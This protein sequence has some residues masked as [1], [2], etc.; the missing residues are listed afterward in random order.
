MGVRNLTRSHPHTTH[1][2]HRAQPMQWHPHQHQN[3]SENAPCCCVWRA[4]RPHTHAT[5]R[6]HRAQPMQWQP[7][8]HQHNS[9]NVPCCRG[10]EAGIV[11]RPCRSLATAPTTKLRVL[12]LTNTFCQKCPKLAFCCFQ[13]SPHSDGCSQPQPCAKLQ[14]PSPSSSLRCTPLRCPFVARLPHQHYPPSLDFAK[15]SHL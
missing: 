10:G 11:E 4:M 9:E 5:H 8:Q 13:T 1:R 7:H 6:T 15:V 3:N 14:P 12:V 2:I